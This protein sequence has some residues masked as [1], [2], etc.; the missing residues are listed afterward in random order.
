MKVRRNRAFVA[1]ATLTGIVVVLAG[2]LYM[3]R[4]PGDAVE[5]ST[6]EAPSEKQAVRPSPDSGATVDQNQYMLDQIPLMQLTDEVRNI[7]SQLPGNP[8][9]GTKGEVS[10]KRM[11]IYW[12]GEV[13]DSVTAAVQKTVALGYTIDVQPAL[14]SAADLMS[15]AAV[16]ATT[17][18][19]PNGL[20]VRVENDGS[21]L[22]VMYPGLDGKSEYDAND[23]VLAA[24]DVVRGLGV[25]VRQEKAPEGGS[26]TLAK[27]E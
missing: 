3:T 26:H 2:V 19:K 25:A 16:L 14:H 9:G 7:S 18:G 22:I 17:A 23:A 8:F 11:T 15:V 24:I 20:T 1:A 27:R 4:T 5:Q 13:P 6:S 12:K 21:G 10:E